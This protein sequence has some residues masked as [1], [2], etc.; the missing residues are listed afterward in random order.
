MR[1]FIF[2][3]AI[4]IA[5]S[6]L[7]QSV[8]ERPIVYQVPDMK[9]VQVRENIEYR[10]V[11]DTSL[12]LDVYYPP[13]FDRKK[14]FPVVVFNNGVGSLDLLKW[15]V[16]QDWAKLMAANGL[17]AV[18]HQ[19]RPN[20]ATTMDDC[21]AVIDYLRD[22][23]KEL[24]MDVD[25]IGIWTCSGNSPRGMA[26]ALKPGRPYIRTLVVYYGGP[27]SLGQMRQDVP[28]LI[29]RAGLDA[30]FLN[31][32]IENFMREALV[33]D[34]RIELINYLEGI[35][36][37]D[38]YTNTKESK[39]IIK[40]TVDFLKKNL[41]NPVPTMNE[42]LLTNR[43]FMW[44]MNAGKSN[45]AIDA[46]R[47]AVVRYRADST[48]QPFYN[49]VIRED[50]LNA[51]AY[52]L[53]RN[54][55]QAEALETFKLMVET[56]PSSPNAFDGLADAYEALG[57]KTEAISNSEKSLALLEKDTTMNEQRKT[58]IRRSAE[59]KIRRLKSQ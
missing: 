11:N 5:G 29:V 58:S 9:K 34:I 46:F 27:D 19:T 26:L 54:G 56:Y 37:F 23:G 12:K 6:S 39:A 17:I 33:Q 52:W 40:R 2:S 7:A 30:Q 44:M 1:A 14:L 47:K 28:T 38:I 3:I 4:F 43:N 16:Y 22:H 21:A 36:A 45:E 8:T 41:T 25:R 32:G 51:N 57:N 31:M 18:N 20:R 53:L 13:G 55:K 59:D 35:H 24:G 49:G 10:K 48:F 42:T 50:I 15:R